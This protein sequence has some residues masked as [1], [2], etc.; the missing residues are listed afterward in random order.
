M[1]FKIY[2]CIYKN[3]TILSQ[4]REH[5]MARAFGADKIA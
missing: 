5:F 2:K 3:K 1:A 4:M